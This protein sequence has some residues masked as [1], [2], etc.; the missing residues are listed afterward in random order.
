MKHIVSFLHLLLGEHGLNSKA[1]AYEPSA[2]VSLI[3]A[4]PVIK[5]GTQCDRLVCNLDLEP[6][7]PA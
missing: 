3:L 5:P 2:R 7:K 1:L 6:R 4:A